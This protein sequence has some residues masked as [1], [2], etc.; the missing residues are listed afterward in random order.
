MLSVRVTE[1]PA[2]FRWDQ[3]SAAEAEAD[4]T[5]STVVSSEVLT[6]NG[7]PSVRFTLDNADGESTTILYVRTGD[8][9][10]RVA[11]ADGGAPSD[12]AATAFVDSFHLR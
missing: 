3:A 9:L 8:Q 12:R 6:V 1:L 5:G 10:Y 4:R 7:S 11:Y 2:A